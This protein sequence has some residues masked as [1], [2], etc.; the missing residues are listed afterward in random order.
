M[1]WFQG[2][3][4]PLLVWGKANILLLQTL[5]SNTHLERFRNSDTLKFRTLI[6]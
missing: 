6:K 4:V 3:V 5:P 1:D 2:L